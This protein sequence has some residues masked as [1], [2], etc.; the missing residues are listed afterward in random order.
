MNDSI[1][2]STHDP[3]SWRL[4]TDE[5][6]VRDKLPVRM[7]QTKSFLETSGTEK[8][9]VDAKLDCQ[10]SGRLQLMMDESENSQPLFVTFI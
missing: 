3:E 1:S 2:T 5:R 4:E 10:P 6:A 9:R 7:T 8:N